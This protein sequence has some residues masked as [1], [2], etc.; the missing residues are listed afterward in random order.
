MKKEAYWAAFFDK[1]AR[2]E[3]EP[4]KCLC[5]SSEANRQ[6]IY[7][8]VYTFIQGYFGKVLDVGTGNGELS[9][10]LRRHCD[11]T[12]AF[13]IS[14]EMLKLAKQ[15][16]SFDKAYVHL[17]QAS[18]TEAPFSDGL[19][20]LIV[21]SEVLQYV[22][23]F[24]T[25]FDLIGLLKP[26]GMLVISIPH[27]T[28]PVVMEAQKRRPGMFNGIGVEELRHLS[29][30]EGILCLVMPLYLEDDFEKRY[31]RGPICR[32]PDL[33]DIDGANRLVIKIEKDHEGS[34]TYSC[35]E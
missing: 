26:G 5:F 3:T 29:E 7:D 13:D 27:R 2:S 1:R 33:D 25:V 15:K 22:P 31:I 14:F 23:F 35:V 24:P 32:A 20:D 9:L 12:I 18:L 19:F 30:K 17:C 6:S 8:A 21:A 10:R 28:H 16:L 34:Y 11:L 4:A